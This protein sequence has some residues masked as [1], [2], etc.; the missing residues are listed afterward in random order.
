[1]FALRNI[2]T[3]ELIRF[4]TDVDGYYYVGY[5]NMDDGFWVVNDIAIATAFITKD[6]EPDIGSWLNPFDRNRFI[7][8][9]EVVELTV[10]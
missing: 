7:D 10:K 1:M 9:L 4:D 6:N 5:S 2:H 3:Q 8:E